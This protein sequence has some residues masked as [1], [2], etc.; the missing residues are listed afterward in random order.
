VSGPAAPRPD[1]PG[2]GAGPRR[3]L[4]TLGARPRPSTYPNRQV[5]PPSA[6]GLG[7]PAFA[8]ASRRRRP[9]R[10]HRA[11]PGTCPNRQVDCRFRAV[12]RS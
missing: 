9:G 4:Q 5:P 6:H 7:A 2:Q 11:A 8:A 10:R 1:P 12:W 3:G